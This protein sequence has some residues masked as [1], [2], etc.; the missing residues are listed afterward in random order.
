MMVIKLLFTIICNELIRNEL[1]VIKLLFV[2]I[3]NE[4][5]RNELTV[6]D[7]P[8]LDLLFL[9]LLLLLLF[10]LLLVV[11]LLP[12]HLGGLRFPRVS[13]VLFIVRVT[14]QEN[15]V[16][17]GGRLFFFGF[18]FRPRPHNCRYGVG[19]SILVG[20]EFCCC[21]LDMLV[22]FEVTVEKFSMKFPH[23]QG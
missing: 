3:C 4:L 2:I 14:Q 12:L 5:H 19:K 21:V 9:L 8:P 23:L 22:H 1:N 11:V 6:I 10:L 20:R 13:V 17:F 15:D 16:G 7:I 18:F